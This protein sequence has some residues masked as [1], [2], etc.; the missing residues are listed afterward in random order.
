MVGT[1]AGKGV[2][3]VESCQ[4][5]MDVETRSKS[6]CI[7]SSVRARDSAK[8]NEATKAFSRIDSQDD[9]PSPPY[10]RGMC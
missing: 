2:E 9:M 4:Y 7:W 3:V 10:L 6:G 5:G 8:K 1:S